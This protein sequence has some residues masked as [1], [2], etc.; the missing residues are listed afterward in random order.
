MSEG[1]Y[2]IDLPGKRLI[3]LLELGGR[4]VIF[5]TNYGIR[6]ILQAIVQ[7]RKIDRLLI[8][9]CRQE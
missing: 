1:V 5:H 2:W 6:A 4:E 3:F 7:G 8:A 9:Q